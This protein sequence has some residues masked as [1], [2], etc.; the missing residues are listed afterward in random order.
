MLRNNFLTYQQMQVIFKPYFALHSPKP[1]GGCP[2]TQLL[3]MYRY[4]L[5]HFSRHIEPTGKKRT[6]CIFLSLLEI[7]VKLEFSYWPGDSG[8]LIFHKVHHWDLSGGKLSLKGAILASWSCYLDC[9]GWNCSLS[10][11]GVCFGLQGGNRSVTNTH[12]LGIILITLI[13]ETVAI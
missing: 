3:P 11:Q 10:S 13:G 9:R 12:G 1:H 5:I 8:I 4:A 7:H 6:T 2:L